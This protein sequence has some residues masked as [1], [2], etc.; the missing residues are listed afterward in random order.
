MKVCTDSCLFGALLP[1]LPTG[2]CRVLDIGTGTGLLSLMYAQRNS[3]AQ[4]DALELDEAAFEQAKEN[5]AASPWNA[6]LKA[7][8]GDFKTGGAIKGGEVAYDLIFSNPPFY[9]GDLKSGD[10]KRDQALHST[11][12]GFRDLVKNAAVLL[13]PDGVFAVLIPYSRRGDMLD[14]GEEYGLFPYQE[15][16]VANKEK[17]PFFR[18]IQL[19]SRKAPENQ[20]EEMV[21]REV[22]QEYSLKFKELLSPFY[23]Y[24]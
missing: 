12:L 15:Y 13:K 16:L 9:E 6:R 24:L 4:I 20:Q 19:F 22:N 18:V 10:R 23:L 17:G 1:V 7:V 11:E 2:P 3:N 8:H 21:I 5:F 14:M